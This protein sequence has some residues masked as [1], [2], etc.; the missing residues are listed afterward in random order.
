MV[1]LE[2][3]EEAG[4]RCSRP[5][6]RLGKDRIGGLV[7]C[8]CCV[9]KVCETISGGRGKSGWCVV[10][11]IVTTRV[12]SLLFFGSLDWREG[13][14]RLQIVSKVFIQNVLVL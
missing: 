8:F 1:H 10:H 12:I 13:K 2:W 9:T 3:N 5:S 14:L 4:F 7:D 6:N 11:G